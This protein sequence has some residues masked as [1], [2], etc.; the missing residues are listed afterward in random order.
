MKESWGQ[1]N[2]LKVFLYHSLLLLMPTHHFAII[3]SIL[4]AALF[5]IFNESTALNLQTISG[6]ALRLFHKLNT[7]CDC[8]Y[9]VVL[10]MCVKISCRLITFLYP[11]N[12]QSLPQSGDK[13]SCNWSHPFHLYT[14]VSWNCDYQPTIH[15]DASKESKALF[16]DQAGINWL[17]DPPQKNYPMIIHWP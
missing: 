10:L 14:T 15:W 16:T 6:S 5:P 12:T 2:S 11:I 3:C 7:P 1:L 17:L 9:L 8:Q 4:S 13:E